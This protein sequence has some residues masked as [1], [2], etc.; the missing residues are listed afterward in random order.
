MPGMLVP[1]TIKIWSSFFKLQ[2]IMSRM[3]FD[4]LVHFN[5]YFV[6][7]VFPGNVEALIRL[8]GN[9]NGH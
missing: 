9:L 5:A 2:S 8:G 1:K 7:S 4:I 6:C 3:F